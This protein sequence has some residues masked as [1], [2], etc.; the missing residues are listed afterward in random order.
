VAAAKNEPTTGDL[1]KAINPQST[2]LTAPLLKGHGAHKAR[3]CGAERLDP[4]A[5]RRM[6]RWGERD[7]DKV[8]V[9]AYAKDFSTL[10]EMTEG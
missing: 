5:S 7:N 3:L 2:S 10:L 4:S 6:T 1:L 8:G 9:F